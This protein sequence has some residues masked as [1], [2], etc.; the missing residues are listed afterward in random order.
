[1][2]IL[3]KRLQALFPFLRNFLIYSSGSFLLQG[4]S[5]FLTPLWVACLTPAE[6]GTLE[7]LTTVQSL[8]GFAITVNLTNVMSVNFFHLTQQRRQQLAQELCTTFLFLAVP[9]TL[10]TPLIAHFCGA[11]LLHVSFAPLLICA[12]VLNGLLWFIIQMYQTMLLLQKKASQLAAAQFI[13]GTTLIAGS[14]M[15]VALFHHGVHGIITVRLVLTA[16]F[17]G[18]VLVHNQHSTIWPTPTPLRT[19]RRHCKEGLSFFPSNIALWSFSS[20]HQWSLSQF[21]SLQ[22]TGI[23]ALA[24]KFGQ[25]FQMVVTIPLQKAYTPHLFEE[26]KK[27]DDLGT[28]ESHNKKVMW[29]ALALLVTAC[30][31]GYYVTRPFLHF[32]VPHAYHRALGYIFGVMMSQVLYIGAQ[33]T[34]YLFFYKKK[35]M[36]QT[37]V[38]SVASSVNVGLGLILIPRMGISGAVL[39]SA[40]ANLLYFMLGL[41]YNS[42]LIRREKL[43]ILPAQRTEPDMTPQT[44]PIPKQE[45]QQ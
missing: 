45:Q 37:W 13:Y 35:I 38:L 36:L 26:Y 28:A 11:T 41:Y 18:F 32:F 6:Y 22:D 21:C 29:G 33:F 25:L 1:M 20:G 17:A 8:I 15:S 7:L 9:I 39:A 4:I 44:Q 2:Q 40:S 16:L 42:T 19:V 3:F 14:V 34:L 30:T 31:T 10:I 27:S 12:T 23:Y 5:I 24:N 43:R